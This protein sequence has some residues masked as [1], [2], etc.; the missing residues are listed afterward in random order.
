MLA[1]LS[2][3][4]LTDC[5]RLFLRNYEVR[6][7]IGVHDFEK[8]GEQRVVFNV[9]LFVPLAL[10]TPVAD[11][12]SEVVDYDFMRST[13]AARVNRG[14]IHLQETLC[15][16]VAAALLAHPNVRAV[17]VSTQKPDVYPDCDAVGVE[18][19]RIKEERA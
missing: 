14:H 7:N 4:R 2:H 5:R 12:L 9:E 18:V 6:I 17:A 1:A 3:P 15:D 11:K 19:F 8:R 13:I 16:D 10:S